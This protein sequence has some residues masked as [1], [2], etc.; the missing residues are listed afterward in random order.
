METRRQ[1]RRYSVRT[2]C[3]LRARQDDRLIADETVDAS[4]S[5]LLVRSL[6]R[7]RV[8]EA[9]RVSIRVPGSRMWLEADGTVARVCPGRREGESGET[10]GVVLRKMDG[11]HRLLFATALR[12]HPEA[13]AA[14]GGRRDYA[15]AIQRIADETGDGG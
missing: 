1:H 9:V 5:G 8:G 6:G 7:A 3:V 13:P 10:L 12:R 11:M 15:R 14:R 2:D 4:W